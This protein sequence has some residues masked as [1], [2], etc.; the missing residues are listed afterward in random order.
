MKRFLGLLSIF[1][2]VFATACALAPIPATSS[3]TPP[4]PITR[5]RA[6]DIATQACRIPHLVL[7]GAPRNVRAQLVTL[8]EANQLTSSDGTLT[9]P[10]LS[11][12][13]LVWLVQMD[14]QFQLVGGP[15][16]LPTPAAQSATAAPPQP[17]EG[18]CTVL[19]DANTG[20]F[21]KVRDQA[22]PNAPL[23]TPS[24]V[25]PSGGYPDASATTSKAGLTVLPTPYP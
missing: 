10:G 11:P 20:K 3:A 15:A 14:G 9:S 13:S 4:T 6:I 12:G 7:V 16:P 19:V 18:T 2:L 1:A 24:P 17:F 25:P 8:D 21:I 5:E 23:V 22:N